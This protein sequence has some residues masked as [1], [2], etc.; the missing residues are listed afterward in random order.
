MV[1]ALASGSTPRCVKEEWGPL[2]QIRYGRLLLTK[3]LSR[4]RKPYAGPAVP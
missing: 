1:V 3:Q 2:Y 4:G